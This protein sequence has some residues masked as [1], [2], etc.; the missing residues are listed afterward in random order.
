MSSSSAAT[1]ADPSQPQTPAAQ[2]LMAAIVD[3]SDDAIVSKNLNG[4]VTSWNAGA[5]RMFGY[6]PHEMVGESITKL[7][8]P[9]RQ[10]EEPA[11]LE[12]LR[13]GERVEHFESIRMRKDGTFL[14]VSLTISPVRNSAGEIVGASKIARDI[15]ERK[16]ADRRLKET[17]EELQ[18]ALLKL[19]GANNELRH[20]AQL[21]AE[22]VSTLSHELRT[23]L[24]AISGWLHLLKDEKS[25]SEELAEGLEVIDRNLRVQ[26]QLIDDLL[27]MSRIEAGKI[28]LD[29]QS[30]DLSSVLE[31]AI[32][33]VRPAAEARGIRITKVFSSM[34]GVVMGDRNRLQQIVWNLLTNA[35]KFTPKGGRIHVAT[36]RI[37]SHA[38][39]SV[40]DNGEGIAPQFLPQVFERF[41]QADG[42]TTRRHGGL[43]LGLAIVKNLV[44]MHG[45]EVRARSEGLGKGSTFSVLL[46]LSAA[47]Q[48]SARRAAEERNSAVDAEIPAG[49][50]RGIKVLS[51]D[52]DIDSSNVIRRILE[53]QHAEVRSAHSVIDGLTLVGDFEPHIILCDIGMPEHDGYE[54][55]KQ[56][57]T[58]AGRSIPAVALTALARM[59]DRTRALRAGFQMHVAKPVHAEE[60]IA[61][62]QNMANFPEKAGGV[63]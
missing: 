37:N 15:T 9:D 21:K 45:G 29:M 18:Q 60:L 50:L 3:S 42:S 26:M 24:M 35:I 63:E 47:R 7:I 28:S 44:E 53:K 31:A 36:E 16:R 25:E 20:A 2:W 12:R 1:P 32:E 61:V 51:I 5:V 62:V 23:P 59:E 8:P 57:R 38:E 27:D 33:S 6:E 10:Q 52:D 17:N 13:R 54:F 4:I 58:G 34:D 48:D 30:L 46:P 14:E 41:R 40:S 55:I 43:G 22:F 11:I 19:E 39:I 56:L 49:D